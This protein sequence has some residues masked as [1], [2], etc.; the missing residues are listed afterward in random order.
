MLSLDSP[1]VE[2][3]D[4]VQKKLEG[5]PIQDGDTIR[6]FPIASFNE[7]IVYLQGHVLRPGRYSFRQGMKI[8]DLVSS[9]KDLLPEPSAKYAEIVRLNPPDFRPT[10]VGFDLASAL[11]N[12]ASAPTLEPMDTIRIYGRYDLRSIS[13]SARIWG[14]LASFCHSA[15]P[16]SPLP[17]S[18]FSSTPPGV[19]CARS[20]R[21]ITPCS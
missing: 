4:F 14:R 18:P 5:F 6:I 17:K 10:V 9:Y 12:P 16:S 15:F 19:T 11:S 1:E 13:R 7:D 20:T 2:D 8:T 3:A 21:S